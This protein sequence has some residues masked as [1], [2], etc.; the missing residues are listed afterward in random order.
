[1]RAMN[2][3]FV[4]VHDA[5]DHTSTKEGE[6]QS[7]QTRLEEREGHIRQLEV[8]KG[9]QAVEISKLKEEVKKLEGELKNRDQ[10]MET[11]MAEMADIVHQVM[12]WEAEAIAAKDLLKEVKF[13]KG[14]DIAKAVDEALA[15]FKNSDEFNALLKKDHDA[16]FDAG[17][18]VVFYNI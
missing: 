15:K 7:L 1:M 5:L 2:E 11:L 3:S 6:F 8:L 10:G 14:L 16:S 13:T 12:H 9:N 18:E 17:V 4:V